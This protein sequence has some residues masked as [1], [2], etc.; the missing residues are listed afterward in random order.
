[1]SNLV[2]FGRDISVDLWV[3]GGVAFVVLA[4]VIAVVQ[5]FRL[6][7]GQVKDAWNVALDH[8]Y[9]WGCSYGD[10]SHGSAGYSL[11]GALT[12]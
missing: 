8:P 9:A 12:A 3:S 4:V 11:V 1:M 10:I 2:E 5:N 7:R 6:R